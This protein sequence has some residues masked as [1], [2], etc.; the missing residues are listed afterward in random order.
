MSRVFT[1][2]EANR[3]LPLVSRI[4]E[5]I[6]RD[7]A[8]WREKVEAYEL[9]VARTPRGGASEATARLEA[10]A[11]RLAG[12]IERYLE[13]LSDL[14]IQF[15]GFDMG[16]ID[17]PAEVDGRRVYLCWRLGESRVEH[18]HEVADGYAGRQPLSTLPEL[19]P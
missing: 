11:Q 6:V 18:W 8:R 15:K 9:E 7:Y 1:V 10:E 14:E 17:F 5:D 19:V 2:D 16:L 13:E 12:E 3:T 4:V